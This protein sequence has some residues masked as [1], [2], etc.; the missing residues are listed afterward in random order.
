[1][2]AE[3]HAGDVQRHAPSSVWPRWDRGLVQGKSIQVSL[4][5]CWAASNLP[6]IIPEEARPPTVLAM[7]QNRQKT[8]RTCL[9]SSSTSSGRMGPE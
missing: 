8:G 9:L 4:A 7:G 5:G 2:W 1:V 6:T 3:V